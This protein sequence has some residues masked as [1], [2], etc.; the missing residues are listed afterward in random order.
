[1]KSNNT[2]AISKSCFP[3]DQMSYAEWVRHF[4]VGSNVPL[5]YG[6]SIKY[7]LNKDYDFN[8][9]FKE[10]SQSIFNFSW[11]LERLNIFA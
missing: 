1:M 9:L 6:R 7:D 10:P 2:V 8:K 3:K 4:N 11:I 5:S